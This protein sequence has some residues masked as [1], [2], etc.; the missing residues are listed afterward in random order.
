MKTT[1]KLIVTATV[2]FFSLTVNAQKSV[3]QFSGKFSD[4]VSEKIEYVTHEISSQIESLKSIVKYSPVAF[5]E[6]LYMAE[7]P[8]DYRSIQ[9]QLEKDVKFV[10]SEDLDYYVEKNDNSLTDILKDLELEA[11]YQPVEYYNANELDL[12]QIVSELSKD[13]KYVS[14]AEM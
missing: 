10:P 3:N 5:S 8:F 9:D 11:K 14:S 4:L 13:A 1:H 2:A 12:K 6:D 7:I